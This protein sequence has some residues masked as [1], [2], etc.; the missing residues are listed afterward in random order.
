[1]LEKIKLDI[2]P[3]SLKIM[4][5]IKQNGRIMQG[6]NDKS[7]VA[8]L[9]DCLF[10]YAAKMQASDIHIE[11]QAQF[12]QIRFRIDGV[13]LVVDSL[14]MEINAYVISYLKLMAGMNISEKRLPQDGSILYQEQKLDIRVSVIPTLFGEKMVL[15]LLG[16]Q[17]KLLTLDEMN[18]S[19]ENMQ[20]LQAIIQVA[21]GI[22]AITGPV[23]SGKST[24]L[25]AILK[26]LN[27]PQVNIVTI[28]D[29]I[30]LKIDN[31][32]QMQVNVQAGMDFALGLKAVLRQDPDIVMIGELRDDVV[33]KEA[34]RAALTG[35]LVFTTLHTQNAISVPARL[36][37]MGVNPAMLSIVFTGAISQRLVRRIC[38][39]CKVVYKPVKNSLEAL[40]LGQY[41]QEGM[42]LYRGQ[43]CANC[44]HSGY[45]GRITLQEI[46]TVNDDLKSLIANREIDQKLKRAIHFTGMKSMLDDGIAK[47]LQGETTVQEVWRSLNGMY[48]FK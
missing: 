29:P 10:A 30:E 6:Y 19:R 36:L 39:H 9:I 47:V 40:V 17:D 8:E 48:N 43:G 5:S 27:K 37:N 16:T 12:M 45:S 4:R 46:M 24:L 13:L 41:F 20:K 7:P 28:E 23:N 35:H 22:I 14:P 11:P 33:A 26:H 2:K 18:F 32:N 1:M 15:R 21:S 31:I 34:I 38:P 44:N 42:N 3:L 25:Y